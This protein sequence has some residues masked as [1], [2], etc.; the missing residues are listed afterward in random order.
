MQQKVTELSILYELSSI[1]HNFS[2]IEEI[3][4]VCENKAISLLGNDNCIV[5]IL[6][7]KKSILKPINIKNRTKQLMIRTLTISDL[8]DEVL[9]MRY[10]SKKHAK[11]CK[12]INLLKDPYKPEHCIVLSLNIN[13]QFF[14]LIYINRYNK[15]NEFTDSDINLL[16]IL[17]DKI[18]MVLDNFIA[19][20]DL[21][22]Q[23]ELL[24][25]MIDNIPMAIYMKEVDGDEPRYVM[26]NKSVEKLNDY[27]DIDKDRGKTDKELFPKS[28]AEQFVADDQE[29]I[30][31]GRLK[32]FGESVSK[33][34]N[35]KRQI[36]HQY[37]F[38]LFDNFDNPK[39]IIG[40][41]EDITEKKKMEEELFQAQKMDAVGKLAGGIAHD[42]NNIMAGILGT[43]ELLLIKEHDPRTMHSLNNIV[44][45]TKR[46]AKLTKQI[47][48]FSR[49]GV[50]RMS[51]ID[52][53]ECINEAL[54][55]L[56][57]TIDKT[58]KINSH[59]GAS[60]SIVN[61][62]KSMLINII[63][64]LAI[65]ARDA[66]PKGGSLTIT[67]RNGSIDSDQNYSN[68]NLICI[69]VADNGVGISED[70]KE[71]IF[72]PFFTTKEVGRG[73][74]LGLSTVYGAT[75]KHNG[76][77]QVE[78]SEGNGS[79]FSICFPLVN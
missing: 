27:V 76:T 72:E 39:Y 34:S 57:S 52:I 46:A 55:I 8:P 35:T 12:E 13:D 63:L 64:N 79:S 15:E 32:D 47:L 68:K 25:T 2:S 41:T 38:P 18:E 36:V 43:T 20:E 50:V 58:I 30:K 17:R 37:K 53:H 69:E 56:N 49:K 11:L 44:T 29:V 40:V 14:G 42:F 59:L 9:K 19:K 67:T 21:L 28:V 26:W 24:K 16:N 48:T 60:S 33:T 7:K 10:T 66:M 74:G 23:H 61:G 4:S 51:S 6:D 45:L 77:I 78:S 1:P 71:Q 5:Y 75:L 62:N 65:N 3:C 54:I 31:L 22:L 73:T 70:I